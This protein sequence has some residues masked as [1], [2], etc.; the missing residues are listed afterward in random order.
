M[1]VCAGDKESIEGAYPIGV[2]LINAAS[3]LTKIITGKEIDTLIFIGSAGSYGNY[4]PFDIVT[5][6]A[7]SQ[8]EISSLFNLSYTPLKDVK[9]INVSC[10]TNTIVNSSNYITT[11][12]EVAQK[13]LEMGCDLENMEFFAVLRVAKDFNIK[14]KGIFV[15]TNYCDKFAHSDFIKNLPKAKNI[16]E[17]IVGTIK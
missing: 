16:M 17:N 3:N 7:A 10:E 11:D 14:A 1:I 6:C 13:F 15:V 2:G 5:S 4:K 9:I 12:K 8:I